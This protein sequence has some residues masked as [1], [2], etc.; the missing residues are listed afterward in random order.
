MSNNVAQI[1]PD[2]LARKAEALLRPLTEREK[3][4]NRARNK[5]APVLDRLKPIILAARDKHYS[6]RDIATQLKTAGVTVSAET[7]RR[8]MEP[9]TEEPRPKAKRK[10]KA[11]AAHRAPSSPPNSASITTTSETTIP[12]TQQKPPQ[13]A[14]QPTHAGA[15]RREV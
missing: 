7:V 12:T 15:R 11:A 10:K 9:D 6:W 1:E 4:R 8:Y 3:S 5:F 2:E 13:P 14:Q